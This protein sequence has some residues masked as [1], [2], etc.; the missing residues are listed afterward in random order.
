[1]TY[2]IPEK[3]RVTL[4]IYE[5]S[6]KKVACLVDEPQEKGIHAVQW[7]GKDAHGASMASGIYLCR[8][9]AGGRTDS[10]K[11]VLMR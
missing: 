5:A 8:L 2:Y 7:N 10:K 4:V 1:V 3:C 9:A 6:G 11:M